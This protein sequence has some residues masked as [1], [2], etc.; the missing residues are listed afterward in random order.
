MRFVENAR[1]YNTET[2]ILLK[3]NVTREDLGDGWT[4]WTTRS[5]YL[6]G[7]K[8]DYWMHVEKVAVDRDASIVDKQDYC[9]IVDEEYVRIFNKNTET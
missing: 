7:K 3:R 6:R 5:I 2:G 1:V 9:Y 4:K 8:G